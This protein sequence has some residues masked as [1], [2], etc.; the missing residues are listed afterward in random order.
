MVEVFNN[1][2]EKKRSHEGNP[3]SPMAIVK[4]RMNDSLL[5]KSDNVLS[6]GQKSMI[7]QVKSWQSSASLTEES[8]TPSMKIVKNLVDRRNNHSCSSF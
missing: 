4:T 3:L 6:K 1:F 8:L 7:Y 5:N 2:S